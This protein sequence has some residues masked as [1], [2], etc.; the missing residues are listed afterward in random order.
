M[1]HSHIS[2]NILR[3]GGAGLRGGS[4]EGPRSR[5]RLTGFYLRDATLRGLLSSGPG[6]RVAA[7]GAGGFR[8]MF[9]GRCDRG[10]GRGRA[11]AGR[12]PRRRQTPRRGGRCVSHRRRP[13]G[14]R[15][16]AGCLE[17]TR[18]RRS[19]RL[20]FRGRAAARDDRR[21][22]QRAGWGVALGPG[23]RFPRLPEG[24]GTRQRRDVAR[25]ERLVYERRGLYRRGRRRVSRR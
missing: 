17:T 3:G 7:S 13:A 20:Q 14:S 19:R 1:G 16:P 2:Q 6:P 4:A 22:V 24:R 23:L 25:N 9:G 12:H 10:R 15:R 18:G 21:P 8:R 11:G 5:R